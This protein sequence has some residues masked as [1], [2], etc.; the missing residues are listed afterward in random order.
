MKKLFLFI[1]LFV[2]LVSV[3]Q[4]QLN[5]V[6][7]KVTYLDLPNGEGEITFTA[8]IE[9]KWH[10]YSQKV[11]VDGPIPTSFVITPSKEFKL[12]GVVTEDNAHEI[13]DKSFEA[14]LYVFDNQAVFKQ[15]IKRTSKTGFVIKTSLEYMTC[16]DAQCLPPK[17]LTFDITVPKIF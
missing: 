12:V 1:S 6:T 2:S 11:T 4:Q 13:Y 14:K 3:G 8:I 9:K 5:P 15:K 7:W 10:I 17:T 16:N